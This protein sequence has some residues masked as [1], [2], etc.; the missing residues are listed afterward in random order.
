MDRSI[1]DSFRA[2]RSDSCDRNVVPVKRL[3]HVRQAK[4]LLSIISSTSAERTKDRNKITS[5]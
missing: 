2:E 1:V 3:R 4:T 5:Q